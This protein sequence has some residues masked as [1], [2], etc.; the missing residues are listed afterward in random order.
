MNFLG[1]TTPS[2]VLG[3]VT[4][5][6]QNTG[7]DLWGLLILLGIPLAFWIGMEVIDFIRTSVRPNT[8][9]LA[10]DEATLAHDSWLARVGD[11]LDSK[12]HSNL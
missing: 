3:S 5:G 1:S 10:Q 9:S 4:S 11:E 6:V 2:T 8:N 7:S 12:G